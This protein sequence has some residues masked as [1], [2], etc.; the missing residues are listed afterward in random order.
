MFSGLEC[1]F[2]SF[3]PLANNYAVIIVTYAIKEMIE[4]LCVGEES[5]DCP[6]VET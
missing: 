3:F 4:R 6:P 1:C 5:E 2:N